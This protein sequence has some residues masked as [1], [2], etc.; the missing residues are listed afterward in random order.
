[1]NATN[2]RSRHISTHVDRPLQHVYD[3][4]A[5]PHNLTVWAAGLAR[6]VEEGEDGRW[7]VD[8]PMGRAVVVFAPR[9]AFGV[10]DHAVTLPSGETVHNPMRVLPDGDGCEVVFTVRR[11][12]GMSEE[13][14]ER[15]AAAVRADLDA[16]RRV[17]EEG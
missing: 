12:P 17:M 5:D 7:L 10:L 8:S 15:D 6:S 14:F 2:P 13:E 9:N 4:A 16:L 11:R 1:M 3:F